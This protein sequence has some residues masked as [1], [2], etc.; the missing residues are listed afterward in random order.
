[1][2]TQL[3][4]FIPI[5][6]IKLAQQICSGMA[7]LHAHG[8]GKDILTYDPYVVT[9]YSLFSSS[10]V[11]IHIVHNDL[12][13]DNILLDSQE[14]PKL[15]GNLLFLVIP[16]IIDKIEIEIGIIYIGKHILICFV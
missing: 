12:K 1:M 6:K 4:A 13:P 9:I 15:T 3:I 14:T 2:S 11:T 16:F 5:Q 8:I 7:W 10:A